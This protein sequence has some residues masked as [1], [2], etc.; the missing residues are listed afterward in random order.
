MRIRRGTSFRRGWSGWGR[1]GGGWGRPRRRTRIAG[2]HLEW[3]L[4]I[5]TEGPFLSLGVLAEVFPQGLEADDPGVVAE[6]RARFDGWREEDGAEADEA[7]VR[8][9]LDELLEYGGLVR[10]PGE[11]L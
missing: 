6:V 4:L 8:Y 11:E 9:V 5:D 3:I 1:R 10:E 7:F 2:H